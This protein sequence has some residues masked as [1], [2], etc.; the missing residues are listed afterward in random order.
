MENN[1][2]TYLWSYDLVNNKENV[3]YFEDPQGIEWTQIQPRKLIDM[4]GN[5]LVICDAKRYQFKIYDIV[6]KKII[7]SVNL[8]NE[9]NNENID[10]T[11]YLK[12]SNFNKMIPKVTYK[13]M[14]NRTKVDLIESINLLS[15]NKLLITKTI[16]D[17]VNAKC[18]KFYD[19]WEHNNN[20]WNRIYKNLISGIPLKE[21]N[22][23]LVDLFIENLL[24]SEEYFVAIQPIPFKIDSNFYNL[25]FKDIY[26]LRDKYLEEN[27][28]R[29]SLLI[30]IL[31]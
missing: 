13:L 1:T 28:I 31:K 14:E 25:K 18:H 30:G 10:L 20:K 21:I 15:S 7:D 22:F 26:N 11:E 19:I 24:I 5:K 6:E 2:L 4:F 9:V 16:G 8:N 29:Y 23:S 27:D 3:F 17:S 12:L